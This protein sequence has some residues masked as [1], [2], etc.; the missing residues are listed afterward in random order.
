MRITPMA[1]VAVLSTWLSPPLTLRYASVVMVSLLI[2]DLVLEFV[3][4]MFTSIL[5]PHVLL[6]TKE[7]I[8]TRWSI[9]RSSFIIPLYVHNGEKTLSFWNNI[10]M[11]KHERESIHVQK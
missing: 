6:I 3:I 4:L 2:D 10:S 1:N 7:L 9:F 8:I 11:L 5:P